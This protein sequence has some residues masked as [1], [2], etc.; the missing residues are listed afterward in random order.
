LCSGPV[1]FDPE[2][3]RLAV[4]GIEWFFIQTTVELINAAVASASPRQVS[5]LARY[6]VE[7]RLFHWIVRM[8]CD[9]GVAPQNRQLFAQAAR[10]VPT[11]MPDGVRERL[12]CFFLEETRQLRRWAVG[13]RQRWGV[14]PGKLCTGEAMEPGTL[15]LKASWLFWNYV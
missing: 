12:L 6:V 4:A 1:R 14:K 2:D 7:Y 9:K 5:H 15:Q 11:V 10:V 13:F 8:N 3:R